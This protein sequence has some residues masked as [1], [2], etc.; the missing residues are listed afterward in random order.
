MRG[1]LILGV[2]AVDPGLYGV[3]PPPL[4]AA[5]YDA[6]AMSD[7]AR[8]RGFNVVSGEP[9]LG[10]QAT[11]VS[12][13]SYLSY[14]AR[15]LSQPG[16]VFLLYF[17]GHGSQVP[18]PSWSEWDG[19]NETWCLYDGEVIDHALYIALADFQP[20]VQVLVVSDCCY[21]GASE[22]WESPRA[23]PPPGALARGLPTTLADE[24][25]KHLALS[26]NLQPRLQRGERERIL[27]ADVELIGACA[28]NEL[29]FEG[30]QLGWFT[31]ALLQV[32]EA[33]P[34]LSFKELSREVDQRTPDCQTP[35][36][37]PLSLPW[38]V[39]AMP[40]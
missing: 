2:N 12:L 25:Y 23:L 34:G 35:F 5:E 19:R 17:A 9:L 22:L 15:E 10:N 4:R 28:E 26:C 32:W 33:K 37:A 20:G 39:E 11:R 18:D 31:D 24:A 1:A 29:A 13:S 3:A 30:P 7:F 38:Q 40:F 16:D 21:S 8:S 6:W 14:G 27:R 36:C